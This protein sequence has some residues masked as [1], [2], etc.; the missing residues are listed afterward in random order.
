MEVTGL[1]FASLSD[2]YELKEL[3]IYVAHFVLY[4]YMNRWMLN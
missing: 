4:V 2:S 3:E 1:K